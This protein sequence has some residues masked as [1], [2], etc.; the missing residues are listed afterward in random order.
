MSEETKRIIEIGGHKLE[1]DLREAMQIESYKV[2][3]HVK[4][5]VEE[6][7]SSGDKFKSH[8]GVIVGF[9]AF[10]NTPT[11]VVAYL[12]IDYNGANIQFAYINEKQTTY[13]LCPL[14]DWDIP[15]TKEDVLTKINTEIEK[16]QFEI[17]ELETKKDVFVKMF[18]RYFD[19][20]IKNEKL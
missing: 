5:L 13:E 8:V 6:S 11:I 2:G 20:V 7:Y 12:K 18:G 9:D 1:I 10:E 19:N 15:F 17:R 4:I 14:N 16:K 3:D